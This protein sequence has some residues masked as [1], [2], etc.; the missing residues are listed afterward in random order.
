[1]ENPPVADVFMYLEGARIIRP[2]L[3][4]GLGVFFFF[5]LFFLIQSVAH[6]STFKATVVGEVKRNLSIF[7]VQKEIFLAYCVITGLQASS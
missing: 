4:M 2:V 1:M 3:H 7:I 6:S 5:F